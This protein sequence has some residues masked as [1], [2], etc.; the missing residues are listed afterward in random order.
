MG[1][2]IIAVYLGSVFRTKEVMTN[3]EINDCYVG[4]CPESESWGNL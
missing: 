1:S 4:Q 2:M 3:A